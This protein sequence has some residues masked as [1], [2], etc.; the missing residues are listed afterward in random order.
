MDK[1]KV[2]LG[3]TALVVLMGALMATPIGWLSLIP[4]AW[5]GSKHARDIIT[6]K[7]KLWSES[8]KAGA[9][10]QCGDCGRDIPL[11]DVL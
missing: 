9:Y 2:V 10:F 7:A 11:G 3:G 6:L 5:A 1:L 4:A 8:D